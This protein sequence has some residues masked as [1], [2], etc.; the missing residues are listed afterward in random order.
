[1]KN[2]KI[3]SKIIGDDKPAY[4]IAEIGVNFSTF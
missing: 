1:M 4:I 3:G 2:M